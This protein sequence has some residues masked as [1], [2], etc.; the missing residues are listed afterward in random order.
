MNVKGK[1]D[2]VEERMT[3]YSKWKDNW[4]LYDKIDSEFIRTYREKGCMIVRSFNLK[5][6]L[7][8]DLVYEMISD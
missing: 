6:L 3:T 4:E 1:R 5:E 8:L 7:S 2:E